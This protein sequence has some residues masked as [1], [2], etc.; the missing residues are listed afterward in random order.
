[1]T[2]DLSVLRDAPRTVKRQRP[3]SSFEL[4]GEQITLD[5]QAAEAQ[6]DSERYRMGDEPSS[7]C[8]I[9]HNGIRAPGKGP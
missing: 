3:T 1:M 4:A 5:R 7:L 6:Y 8:F 9:T 2:D